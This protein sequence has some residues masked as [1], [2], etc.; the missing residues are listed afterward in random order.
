M[1]MVVLETQRLTK[2]FGGLMAVRDV[3]LRIEEG[4]LHSVIGPNGAGKTT[5][6]SMLSGH[7]PV[8]KGKIFF[9]GRDV[10]GMR[11][12][13]LSHLGIGRSFQLTNVF[14]ELTVLENV[15]LAVQSRTRY[16]FKLF[17]HVLG[18]LE[19]LRRAME[20][21]EEI[22]L[23]GKA[24]RKASELS[25]GDQRVLELGISLATQPDLLLL[26]EPTSGMSPEETTNMM[27][28]IRHI[29]DQ[30]TVVLIEHDMKVVMAVSDRI[31]VL[32][33]GEVI[34]EGT[35][36]EIRESPE[37]KKAYLGDYSRA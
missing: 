11:P 5:L 19:F 23:A 4:K 37:V 12:D 36:A 27:R 25:H 32:N 6:F 30:I 31:T 15:R 28:F 10:T 33:M 18:F 29:G 7:L 9:K 17:H 1:A 24:K 22:G 20:I 34:A 26:D 8:S 14:P 35:P 2:H 3:N 13:R 21:L 16:G